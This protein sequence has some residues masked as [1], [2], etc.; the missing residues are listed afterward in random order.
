MN[1]ALLLDPALWQAMLLGLRVT[2]LI[3]V[4]SMILGLALALPIAVASAEGGP[5]LR[6][7]AAG[8]VFVFR[9]V[10]LLMLLYLLYYG[11]GQIGPLRETVLWDFVFRSALATAILAFTLSNA[12]YLAEALRGGLATVTQGEREAGFAIGLTPRQVLTRISLPLAL[13]NSIRTIGNE[14]VF[15]V[16]AS[17][18]ASVVAVRDVLGQAQKIGTNYSDN[19]TPLL[20]AAVFYLILVQLIE[21]AVRAADRRL[22][23]GAAAH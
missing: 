7:L 18:I 1:L 8:Y 2:L 12:A 9:G 19:L 11:S 13:R 6:T 22:N 4:L 15:T 3:T 10:P 17:V 23:G 16:K 14:A 21:A 5:V 20:A